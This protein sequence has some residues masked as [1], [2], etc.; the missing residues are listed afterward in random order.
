MKLTKKLLTALLPIAATG[1]IVPAVTSCNK[2]NG[3]VINYGDTVDCLNEK[4]KDYHSINDVKNSVKNHTNPEESKKISLEDLPKWS[5]GEQVRQ[6]MY[7]DFIASHA[8][9]D[10]E[11]DQIKFKLTWSVTSG[12]L[13]MTFATKDGTKI[14]GTT[15]C[16]IAYGADTTKATQI[17]MIVT[18]GTET[19]SIKSYNF[20][21]TEIG[22]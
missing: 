7:Y 18:C 11:K 13:T 16:T 15:T 1:A 2:G 19:Y 6:S 4:E 14:S 20:K 9:F 3:Y 17:N 21:G 8:L 5:D 22:E 10:D 12:V